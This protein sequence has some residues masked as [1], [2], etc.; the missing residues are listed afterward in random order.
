M[1]DGRYSVITN[2]AYNGTT[3]SHKTYIT[4]ALVCGTYNNNTADRSFLLFTE[5]AGMLYATARSVREERS[6]QR[7]ALQDFSRIRVTLVKGK[8]GWRIGSVEAQTNYFR[9]AT[10]RQARGGVSA[11]V[12][13]VRRL[14]TGE[15]AHPAAF[16]D[17][18][19]AL[20]A[21]LT[22][23][24]EVLLVSEYFTLRLLAKLGYIAP[25][26]AYQVL[27]DEAH[28]WHDVSV[29]PPEAVTAIA[30]GLQGSHL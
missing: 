2:V 9:A 6:K 14:M 11:V 16:E 7:F 5:R 26:P 1:G 13:L 20:E 29:L 27:L 10:T 24:D 30:Q 4:E 19:T 15:D 17:T 22:T 3:V 21:I 18:I 28:W 23:K 12:R 25:H 8:S